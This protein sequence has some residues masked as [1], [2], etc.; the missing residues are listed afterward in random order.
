MGEGVDGKVDQLHIGFSRT[1]YHI[2]IGIVYAQ[3]QL[4][5]S[6]LIDFEFGDEIAI[7]GLLL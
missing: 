7:L 5:D 6:L 3:N 2:N 1:R 4:G